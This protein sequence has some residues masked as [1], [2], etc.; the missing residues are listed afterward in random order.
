MDIAANTTSQNS[1]IT[2]YRDGKQRERAF[3][4]FE[5]MWGTGFISDLLMSYNAEWNATGA[6]LQIAR[7]D[8]PVDPRE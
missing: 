5:D 1:V 3:S 4:V 8:G 7:R 6:L 2:A